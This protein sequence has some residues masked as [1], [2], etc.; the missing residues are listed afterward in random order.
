M[1]DSIQRSD[2]LDRRLERSGSIATL[3]ETG[4]RNRR[5]IHLLWVAI[6]LDVLLSVALGVTALR[7][8]QVA[9]QAAS[10]QQQQHTACLAAND[11][12]TAQRELWDYLLSLPPSSPR[13]ATQEAQLEQFRAYVNRVLA[14]RRC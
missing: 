11:A 10:L 4:R 8:S 7:A 3:A 12:R 14:P 13:T 9:A 6:V 2:D 5:M 1:T